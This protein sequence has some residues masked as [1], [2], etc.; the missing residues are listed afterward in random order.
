MT[1]PASLQA[2][3]AILLVLATIIFVIGI[4]AERSLAG[5]TAET[6]QSESAAA[7]SD[8]VSEE[9]ASEGAENHEE[10]EEAERTS[11]VGVQVASE[12]EGGE[13]EEHA[14][15]ASETILGVN[16]ESTTAVAAAVAISLLLAA[17]L[18]FWGT[19]AVLVIAAGF[20]LLFAALDVREVLHQVNESRGGL[21][22]V[23]L[24]AAAL[25][26]GVAIVAGLALARQ[27]A[28]RSP[29]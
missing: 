12:P 16:P 13:A 3:A 17:A 27:N 22:A 28:R 11:E 9:P 21:A 19:P 20:A 15:E 14:D 8:E 25:H 23:A 18:W 2:A 5:E 1:R 4:T 6:R 24:V 26:V 7:T 10:G 29:A